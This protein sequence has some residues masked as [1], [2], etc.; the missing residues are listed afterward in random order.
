LDGL[1]RSYDALGI[2]QDVASEALAR[3]GSLGESQIAAWDNIIP[4]DEG[5]I[6]LQISE[7]GRD[8]ESPRIWEVVDVSGGY[9]G[10]VSI[11]SQY[12]LRA[13][14]GNTGVAYSYDELGA[15]S[16]NILRI[17]VP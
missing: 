3:I 16:L 15:G 2:P 6:W 12:S 4:D 10:S 1:R 9:L 5:R 11:P 13:V 8:L 7:C 17:P 14:R